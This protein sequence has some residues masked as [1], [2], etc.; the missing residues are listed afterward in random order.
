MRD[1]WYADKRDLVKW[2]VVLTLAE[3]Y[4]ARHILQVLYHRPSAWA[5]L[6]ID[7]DKV[8]LPDAVVRHFRD[9]GTIVN[10]AARVP[11]EVVAEDLVDRR[12]YQRCVV[13]RLRACT[14]L[15]GIVLLD[16]DTGL[17]PKVAGLEHV[18]ETELCEVW[19]ELQPGDVL[20][21]YQHQ[22]NRRGE[23]W[24]EETRAQFAEALGIDPRT[25][26]LAWSER[27]ARDVAFFYAQKTG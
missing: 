24:V 6:D 23:P 3:R 1:Q 8:P 27:I 21:L 12:E 25:A 9:P 16:P 13:E 10:I 20:I 5:E 17:A 4:A 7:G 18:V 15:P 26:T 14:R 19:R 11:V 22:T 2:G